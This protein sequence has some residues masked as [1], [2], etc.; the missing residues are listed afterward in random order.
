MGWRRFCPG[1]SLSF[2][3]FALLCLVAS[4]SA[5]CG[6]GA[7]SARVAW[8]SPRPRCLGPLAFLLRRGAVVACCPVPWCVRPCSAFLFFF[9]FF[10]RRLFSSSFLAGVAASRLASWLLAS[11]CPSSALLPSR[12]LA[13]ARWFALVL[14]L[15]AVRLGSTPELR[16]GVRSECSPASLCFAKS[17]CDDFRVLVT[18]ESGA[19]TLLRWVTALCVRISLC[20]SG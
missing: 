14:P 8:L 18:V 20:R 16:F 15:V 2:S 11:L 5:A 10:F 4:L 19:P 17:S 3:R 12:R 9:F 1:F 6:V 7:L 13:L